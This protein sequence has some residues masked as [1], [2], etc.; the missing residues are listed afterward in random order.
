VAACL[1]AAVQ[2]TNLAPLTL[3]TAEEYPTAKCLDGSPM[4]YYL[5]PSTT[6]ASSKNWL[7]VLNGGGLCTHEADCQ[8][9]TKTELGSSLYFKNETDLDFFSFTSSDAGNPFA[10]WNMVFVP[11]CCG[12]M[13]SGQRTVATNETYV[14]PR[15][16]LRANACCRSYTLARTYMCGLTGSS[17]P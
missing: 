4:G 15:S 7:L 8:A 11:Y 13:H 5:R 10:D 16:R 12:S 17:R 2:A 14:R 1:A 3:L 9:R 6:T